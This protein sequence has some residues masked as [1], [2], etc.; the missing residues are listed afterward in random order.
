MCVLL[1]ANPTHGSGPILQQARAT[2]SLTMHLNQ[3]AWRE[4][5]KGSQRLA[6][7]LLLWRRGLKT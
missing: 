6:L 2:S 4:S 1:D 5:R 3:R 7:F